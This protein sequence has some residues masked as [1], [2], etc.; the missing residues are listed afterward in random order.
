M[1][2]FDYIRPASIPDAI[3]AAAEPG[4]AYLAGGTNL[5][6]LMKGGVTSPQRIVDIS[7]LPE[8]NRIERLEDGG[9]R[10]G[11]LVR[12]A[13]LA[14]DAAFAKAYPMV[15]EA[16]LSGA[17]AQ[18][19]NAATV[20]GN[21]LQRTRC[22]YFYDTASAC[23]KRVSG[24]G[25][26]ALGGEN[27]LHAVLGWSDACIATHP[28]DFCV[29]LV[30]LDAVVEIEGKQGRRHVTLPEF[31]LLPGE[32]PQREN[33]LE[34]G[35]LIVAVRLPAEAAS[36]AAN[37]RYLKVRERTSYAFAVVSAAAALVVDGGK[38]RAARLA[39]GGVA[40]KPWRARAAEAMLLGADA[41]EATFASAA[42]AALA[43]ASPSGDNAFKIE[44]AR[45]IV[46]RALT[47]AQAGTPERLP[48][49]PASPFSNIPGARHDA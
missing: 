31:H 38:I 41:N 10:I 5:L 47:S 24:A 30:A 18:L 28:S 1:R 19:R 34:P 40:P 9:L 15:A 27:R 11:A 23:N 33:A 35:D 45:R 4:S 43:D 36:F 37:A 42:D 17:S 22:S 29:P 21:L 32:T 39:L 20:G 6:D 49:L 12:N 2:D 44:L 13:D 25:C 48:A 46:V 26:A 16:L 7:R 14:H 8:L 3:A